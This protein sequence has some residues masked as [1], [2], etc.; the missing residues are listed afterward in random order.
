MKDQYG[1]YV[2]QCVIE[3]KLS[4]INAQIYQFIKGEIVVLAN[5]KFSSNAVEKLIEFSAEDLRK[6]I[7]AEILHLESYASTLLNPFGNYV[8]QKAL[9]FGCKSQRDEMFQVW[10]RW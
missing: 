5:E 8:I 1:N 6:E 7:I 4:K 10:R 3:Q 9:E 2:I